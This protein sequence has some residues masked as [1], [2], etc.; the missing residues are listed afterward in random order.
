MYEEL[1]RRY[2]DIVT[3]LLRRVFEEE[4]S[5]IE[6]AADMIVETAENQGVVHVIGAGHSAI[7][8]EEMFYRAGGLAIVNPIIDNDITVAHGAAKSTMME[9][10]Q[11]YAEVLLKAA[12]VSPKDTVIVVSTS[13]VNTFPIEAA[14]KAK[15]MG[16]KTIG[17]TSIAY[18]STLEPRNPWGKHLYEVVDVAIDNKVPRGDAVL[19]IGNGIKTAPVSTIV[20]CYIV[21]SI[22]AVASRKMLE[23]GTIPP[24]WISSHLP[25]AKE[26]NEKLFKEYRSR[27]PLL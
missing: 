21:H 25:E 5:K 4:W 19:D 13:G 7:V 11:G 22:V 17:I 8:G 6:R 18:S 1:G 9:H 26:H 3:E 24:I 14:I 10:V 20:N 16:A 2:L 15:E 23:K 12:R 27:I